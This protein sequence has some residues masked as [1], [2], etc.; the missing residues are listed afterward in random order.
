MYIH[1]NVVFCVS[2]LGAMLI[3]F[4]CAFPLFGQICKGKKLN[5]NPIVFSQNTGV[6][7]MYFFF[8]T[9]LDAMDVSFNGIF[10]L[11]EKINMNWL[12]LIVISRTKK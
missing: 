2:S 7:I 5:W 1:P 4:D 6:P 8:Y 3:Y 9:S 12:E 10:L 11:S